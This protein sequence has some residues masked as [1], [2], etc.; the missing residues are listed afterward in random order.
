MPAPEGNQFW[1]ARSKHGRDRIIKDPETLVIAADEYFKWCIDNPII[2]IDYKSSGGG[3]VKVEIPHPRVFKKDEF[4]RFCG[5]CD[6]RVIRDLHTVSEDF[7]RVVTHIEGVIA[8]QK[9]TYATVGMFNPSII[10]RDLGLADKQE[11]KHSGEVK[12]TI[13]NLGQGLKPDESTS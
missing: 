2:E 9:Y 8:D 10:A 13:I 4:A 1:K 5:C 11:Q 3:L 6:W 12:Q 7:S